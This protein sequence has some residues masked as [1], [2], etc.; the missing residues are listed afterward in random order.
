MIGWE[1][2]ALAAAVAV[3]AFLVGSMVYVVVK[4]WRDG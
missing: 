3:V 1:W 2:L 4:D